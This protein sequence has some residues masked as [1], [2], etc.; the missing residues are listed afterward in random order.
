MQHVTV[1]T[2]FVDVQTGEEVKELPKIFDR[3]ALKEGFVLSAHLSWKNKWIHYKVTGVE[4]Q[5]G[6]TVV[7]QVKKIRFNTPTKIFIAVSIL[8]GLAVGAGVAAY[9]LM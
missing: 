3:A 6:D 5:A 2:V 4:E 1:T 9:F 8:L 7:V